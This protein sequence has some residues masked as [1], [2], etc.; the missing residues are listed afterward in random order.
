MERRGAFH[1]AGNRASAELVA[2]ADS[3]EVVGAGKFGVL[4]SGKFSEMEKWRDCDAK[5]ESVAGRIDS[6][7]MRNGF[8]RTG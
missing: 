5:H 8:D 6:I 1:P 7:R 3:M 4:G 2:G